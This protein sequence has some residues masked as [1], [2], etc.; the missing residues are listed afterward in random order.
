MEDLCQANRNSKT[1][2]CLCHEQTYL[3]LFS[4]SQNSAGVCTAINSSRR[5][6]TS[7]K[8]VGGV[9]LF[10]YIYLCKIFIRFI[11]GCVKIY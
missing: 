7:R 5:V 1:D 11:S 8:W 4:F 9:V 6:T 2:I 3:C 10:K